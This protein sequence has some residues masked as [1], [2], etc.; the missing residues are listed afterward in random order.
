MSGSKRR[1]IKAWVL[2][3]EIQPGGPSPVASDGEVAAILPAMW[4]EDRVCDVLER[5]YLERAATPVELMACKYSE[6]L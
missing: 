3:W 4:G 1:S 2:Y 5:L 6:V